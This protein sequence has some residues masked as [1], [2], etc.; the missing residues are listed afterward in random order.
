[1]YKWLIVLAVSLAGCQS[2]VAKPPSST[3]MPYTSQAAQLAAP[4][5][6]L[7]YTVPHLKLYTV[8]HLKR[9]S[10]IASTPIMPIKLEIPS[11]RLNTS[12]EPVGILANGQM[13]VPKSFDKAGILS[14]W[15]KPGEKGSAVISGHFD[16]YTGPAVFYKLRKLKAGDTIFVTDRSNKKLTFVISKVESFKTKEAPLDLIFTNAETSHLNLITCAG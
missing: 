11:I 8:P 6:P 15:T 2:P 12:V 16:H 4:P 14:P 7:V 3:S 9:S 13:G 10:K 5:R 1:M